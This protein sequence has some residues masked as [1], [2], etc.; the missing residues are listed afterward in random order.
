MSCKYCASRKTASNEVQAVKKRD[1]YSIK[2]IGL[3]I[4][5]DVISEKKILFI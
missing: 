1:K 3:D 4:L 5:T 2:S